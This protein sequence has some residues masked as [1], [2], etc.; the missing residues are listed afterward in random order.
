MT[1]GARVEGNKARGHLSL[2]LRR[3]LRKKIAVISLSVL[4]VI[5][6]AGILAPWVSPYGYQEQ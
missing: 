4:V 3:L 6:G 1:L 5:Y 2:A